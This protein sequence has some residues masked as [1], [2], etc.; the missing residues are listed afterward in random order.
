MP[1]GSNH[2]FR[3]DLYRVFTVK[4]SN[5]CYARWSNPAA[6]RSAIPRNLHRNDHAWWDSIPDLGYHKTYSLPDGSDALFY[7]V[8]C[9]VL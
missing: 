6:H 2:L 5:R 9:D 7:G 8:V 4:I 3:G 1:A